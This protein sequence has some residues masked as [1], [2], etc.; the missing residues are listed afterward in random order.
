MELTVSEFDQKLATQALHLA[1]EGP[2]NIGKGHAS[3]VLNQQ[4]GFVHHEVDA[5]IQQQLGLGSME[6]LTQWLFP[7]PE[8]PPDNV[9]VIIREAEYLE[10][11][12]T[13][14]RAAPI[15]N[16]G[17]LILDTSGS[18]A[19]LKTVYGWLPENFLVVY[20][21]VRMEQLDLMFE[22]FM[23]E[24]K[25]VLWQ[26]NYK[27]RAGETR[28]ETLR[29]CYPELLTLRDKRYQMMADV[30]LERDL[31]NS[32]KLTA[33]SFLEEVRAQLPTG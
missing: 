20:L 30:T 25:P 26:G 33:Q 2:S 6:E 22:R 5:V 23:D 21:K 3:M 10:A 4:L 14:T 28:E 12:T 8:T 18:V 31:E 17:N 1:V 11:E 27:P 24:P 19:H 32:A 7:D 13:A 29:R 9:G 15:N 16:P